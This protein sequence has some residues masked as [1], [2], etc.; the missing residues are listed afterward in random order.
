MQRS[1][2]LGLVGVAILVALGIALCALRDN[3]DGPAL[4]ALNAQGFRGVAITD[5]SI[6]GGWYGCSEGELAYEARA[7][8]PRDEVV[9]VIVCCGAGLQGCTTTKACTIRT[10]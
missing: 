9:T 5:R 6:L 4:R 2:L 10:R 3:D 7:V 1:D 8:N